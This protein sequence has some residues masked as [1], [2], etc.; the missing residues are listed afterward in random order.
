VSAAAPPSASSNKQVGGELHTHD[1]RRQISLYVVQLLGGEFVNKM[2]RFG[3][4][5]VLARALS[6]SAFG[7]LNVSIAISGIALIASSLGLP[8]LGARESAL[9]P[10]R[11]G[12][13][14]GHVAVTRN[15]VLAAVSTASILTAT[16]VWPGHTPLLVIAAVMAMFMAASGDWLARG[17][18][19]MT[20]A[21][22][23]NA[24]GGFAVLG[25]SLVIVTISNSATAALTAFA[26]GEFVVAA[27]LWANLL[28]DYKIE[29]G[30]SG[31]S[32]MLRRARPL[33]LSSLAVYSYYANIDTIIIAGSRSNSEAGL[34]SA[35]YRLFLVLNLV[36][37]FAA[38]AM[39]PILTRLA[40]ANEEG[41]ADRLIRSTLAV[42]AGYGLVTLALVEL[43]GGEILALLFGARFR[44]AAGTFVLL[45]A[46][47][48]WY[49]VGYPAGYSLIARAEP[50]RFL[51]GAATASIL[52]I[53]LDIALIPSFGMSGAGGAT[54]AAFAAAT[55]VWLSG[56][57]LLN[58]STLLILTS[59]TV[60]SAAAIFVTSFGDNWHFEGLGTQLVGAGTLAVAI[61]LLL[62]GRPFKLAHVRPTVV[63]QR[64]AK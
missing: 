1:P 63:R 42:L 3:A 2:L 27:V 54:M 46:G 61:A 24:A 21:A 34:Y 52:S 6:A 26:L 33:A 40:D 30:I 51:R 60:T 11:A 5:V 13:L 32:S 57:R 7:L 59:L 56:R 29:I 10:Q 4:L 43:V 20:L 49:S 18:E 14:A 15:L 47:V 35:P 53:I 17:L 19:H 31:M 37:V 58:R 39:L 50:A 55:L 36:A 28:R 25:A 45:A 12:W 48:A 9:A 22:M 38:Y 23:A 8:E 62:S 64:G 16:V 44:V 41:D